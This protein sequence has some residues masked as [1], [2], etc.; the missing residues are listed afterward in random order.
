MD[1]VSVCTIEAG[2]ILWPSLLSHLERVE[3]K[4]WII[5]EGKI[6]PKH[7]VLAAIGDD[8]VVGHI[9]VRLQPLETKTV[10]G[11]AAFPIALDG[12]SLTETFVQT[13]AV[14]ENHRRRGIGIALQKDALELSHRLGAYQMR[15][16]CSSDKSANYRLKLSMGFCAHPEKQH[17]ERLKCDVWGVYFVKRTG[18][19]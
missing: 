10:E 4:K 14:D 15:S 17:I 2:D 9:S 13:F 19:S 8:R 12:V 16:W 1:E 6:R 7:H 18:V 11:D 3:M 5:E